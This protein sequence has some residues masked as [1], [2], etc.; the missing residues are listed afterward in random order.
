MNVRICYLVSLLC[1]F[2]GNRSACAKDV[3]VDAS[4]AGG[5]IVVEKIEG[6]TVTV[7]QDRRDT[8]DWWFYWCFRVRGAAGRTLTFNFTDGA[9]IG[10]RGPA[11]STDEGVTWKWL[12]ATKDTKA[13]SFKFPEAADS[14]RFSFGMPYTE[15]NLKSFL[16]R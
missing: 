6:D 15:A 2:A 13:F 10:V 1:I 12:G 8:K 3:Q 4:F 9:P 7:H 5:N 14:V 16:A 11:Y